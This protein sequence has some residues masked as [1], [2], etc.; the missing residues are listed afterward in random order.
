MPTA[1]WTSISQFGHT[2]PKQ[3]EDK[4]MTKASEGT[5][6]NPADPTQIPT[7]SATTPMSILSVLIHKETMDPERIERLLDLQFKWE[8]N[9]ARKAYNKAFS[10]WKAL[11]VAPTKTEHVSYQ[12][13][14]DQTVEY[15][16]DDV[17]VTLHKVNETMAQFGLSIRFNTQ[18]V[19]G[20]V[21]VTAI[22]SHELGHSEKTSLPAP[23]DKSGSKNDIQAVGSSIRYLMRYTLNAL[24][25]LAPPGDPN[26]G[27]LTITSEEVELVRARLIELGR[28]ESALL[29]WL[30]MPGGKV[31]SI[32]RHQFGRVTAQLDMTP[33]SKKADG[34]RKPKK[35]KTKAKAKPKPTEAK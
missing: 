5:L 1:R 7:A 11:N 33:A 10:Q 21:I 9:E 3:F 4:P 35:A 31:E 29:N 14:L 15:W 23:P 22:C 8:A 18:H 24:L 20:L 26:E 34:L 2:T 19:D 12:N 16:H 32:K 17:G 27:H 13:T 28:K 25:G 6:V 30:G